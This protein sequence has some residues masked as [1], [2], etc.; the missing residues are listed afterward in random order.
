VMPKAALT[1]NSQISNQATI[2]FD[3]NAPIDTNAFVNTGRG[4][5]AR[6]SK[7]QNL[8]PGD[9]TPLLRMLVAGQAL[10]FSGGSRHSK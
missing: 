2:V 9:A 10:G 8:R 1:T 3:K 4:S 7:L 6:S 5:A